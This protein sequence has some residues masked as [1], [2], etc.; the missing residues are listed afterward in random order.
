MRGNNIW[1]VYRHVGVVKH[2]CTW[3]WFWKWRGT[4]FIIHGESW[5]LCDINC[6]D[7]TI[8]GCVHVHMW[9][10]IFIC[11]YLCSKYSLCC[12][13]DNLFSQNFRL[14]CF[15]LLPLFPIDDLSLH[16]SRWPWTH[17]YCII[18][19]IIIKNK[20]GKTFKKGIL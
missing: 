20:F 14:I 17:I 6:M 11:V 12:Q 3:C 19:K 8:I 5:T 10:H 4:L 2:V 15:F 13:F 1:W 18:I 16:F 9:W 7:M